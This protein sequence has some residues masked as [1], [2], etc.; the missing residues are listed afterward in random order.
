MAVKRSKKAQYSL[1]NERRRLKVR[2]ERLRAS[3]NQRLGQ[4]WVAKVATRVRE[5]SETQP[6]YRTFVHEDDLMTAA[7]FYHYGYDLLL[8]QGTEASIEQ[9]FSMLQELGLSG[10]SCHLP[11][12]PEQPSA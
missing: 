3:R 4:E 7:A 2:Q 6:L 10:N 1:S 11:T 8:E 9:F 12:V 5:A